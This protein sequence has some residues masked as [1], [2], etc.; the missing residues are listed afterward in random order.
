MKRPNGSLEIEN[1]NDLNRE[2]SPLGEHIL[3]GKAD[4]EHCFSLPLQSERAEGGAWQPSLKLSAYAER[5][6]RAYKTQF[7]TATGE[8]EQVT[9][10]YNPGRTISLTVS[11]KF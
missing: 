9:R 1:L 11:Y 3:S 8:I 4:W 7:F 6:T 5:R 10:S 2:L